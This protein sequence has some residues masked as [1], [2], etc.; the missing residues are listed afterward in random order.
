MSIGGSR[1]ARLS[2]V[3]ISVML[4]LGRGIKG[5]HT[6]S[7]E[8]GLGEGVIRG[9]YRRLRELGLLEVFRGGG[10]LTPEG[11]RS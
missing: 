5:R 2:A 6:L 3:E 7:R 9:V 4:A 8:L 1:G 10:R 11:I